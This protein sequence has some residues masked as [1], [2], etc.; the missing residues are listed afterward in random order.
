MIILC[1]LKPYEEDS[2]RE[3]NFYVCIACIENV[4]GWSTQQYILLA[5]MSYDDVQ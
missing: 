1:S 5:K 4:A 3:F 2:L